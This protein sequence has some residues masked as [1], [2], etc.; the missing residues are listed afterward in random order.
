MIRFSIIIP[1]IGRSFEVDR[2]LSSLAATKY[3]ELEI[4]VV[5]QNEQGILKNIIDKYSKELN[6]QH[7]RVTFRGASKARNYGFNLTSG[8]IVNFA[9]DDEIVKSNIFEYLV[10]Q[11]SNVKADA[12][13]VKVLDPIK[14][15][16]AQIN[17][18]GEAQEVDASN[19][20]FTTI[21][22]NMFWRREALVEIGRFDE[23]LGV[24]RYFGSE[25]SADLVIRALGSKKR[26]LYMPE[27]AIYH[28]DKR[29]E[30]AI[31][32]YRYGRGFGYLMRKHW[33]SD[34]I[35]RYARRYLINGAVAAFVFLLPRPRR[36]FSYFARLAG[37]IVG[38]Q[39]SASEM[40]WA[41]KDR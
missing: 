35:S 21:E 29:H 40:D 28:Q 16:P 12:L 26:I 1:T 7:E 15:K 32:S 36:S 20:F 38:F 11:L 33:G 9:D 13:S 3:P 30:S 2:L 22:F 19:Y 37:V 8:E 17:Y 25:E 41:R 34:S 24:G 4:V 31:K 6:I 23:K 10:A 27:P 5:D 14:G 39:A 18:P